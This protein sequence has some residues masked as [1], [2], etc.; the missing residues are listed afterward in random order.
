MGRTES[1]ASVEQQRQH[2]ECAKVFDFII[3][4]VVTA[5]SPLTKIMP[6]QLEIKGFERQQ[7]AES[8]HYHKQ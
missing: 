7:C 1:Y 8:H 5:N 3:R 6:W 2:Q 4:K